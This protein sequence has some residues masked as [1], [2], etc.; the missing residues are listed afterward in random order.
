M[1]EYMSLT[2]ESEVLVQR[3][4]SGDDL[5]K[6]GE[7]AKAL[8]LR[9]RDLRPTCGDGPRELFC[10]FDSNLKT[11]LQERNAS[12]VA[13]V[14]TA[15]DLLAEA[16]DPASWRGK[17]YVTY[18]AELR[19]R[20]YAIG[21]VG[22]TRKTLRAELELGISEAFAS[23]PRRSCTPE[24]CEPASDADVFALADAWVEANSN[25]RARSG[26]SRASKRRR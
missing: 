22:P 26:R 16:A 17:S 25:H 21:D 12:Y 20:F 3:L 11:V 8:Y 15:R 1:H 14:A 24:P 7:A 10:R 19:D 9:W 5:R 18:A 6:L 13:A 23:R 2:H 4:R